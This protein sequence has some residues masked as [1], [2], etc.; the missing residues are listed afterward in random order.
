MFTFV[1]T[2]SI[3][4][5]SDGL[6]FTCSITINIDVAEITR[7]YVSDGD[8]DDVSTAPRPHLGYISDGF[9]GGTE[10]ARAAA[11]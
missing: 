2:S 9:L 1:L 10:R 8:L 5:I 11:R 4:R 7:G 3:A 6:P